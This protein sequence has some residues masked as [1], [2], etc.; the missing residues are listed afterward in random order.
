MKQ[1]DMPFTENGIIPDIIL[2]PHSI[3]SRMTIGQLIE[4]VYGKVCAIKGAPC[5]AT[6]FQEKNINNAMDE[7]ETFGFNRYGNEKLFCGKTGRVIDAEIYIA[8]C[9]YQRLQKFVLD[10]IY[11]IKR[12][13]TDIVTRQPVNGGK[14]KGGGLKLGEMEK[15]TILSRGASRVLLEKYSVDSDGYET[16]ICTGCGTMNIA[17]NTKTKKYICH[18]CGEAINVAKVKSTWSSKAF[19]QQIEST[20]VNVEFKL[21]PFE[22]E[23]GR[24]MPYTKKSVKSSARPKTKKVVEETEKI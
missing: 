10:A 5:D 17:V 15:D 7:L 23:T 4:G 21:K 20:N 13:Q 6:I 2:N 12:G 11:S 18:K 19:F 24:N 14:S 16:Y 3:P 9:F 1:S 8:P 22:F